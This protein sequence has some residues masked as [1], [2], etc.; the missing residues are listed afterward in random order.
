M[1]LVIGKPDCIYCKNAII[2]LNF[3]NQNYLY[4]FELIKPDNIYIYSCISVNL[5][6]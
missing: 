5:I 1:Y 3:K 2:L 4:R 6:K